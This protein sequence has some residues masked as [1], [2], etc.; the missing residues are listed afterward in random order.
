MIIDKNLF[1]KFLR[2]ISLDG[3]INDILLTFDDQGM[4]AKVKNASSSIVLAGILKK[5]A[6][7]NYQPLN[8]KIGLKS[9]E[10]LL[11]VLKKYDHELIILIDEEK[12]N[13]TFHD[14]KKRINYQLL[15]PD[16]VDSHI[17]ALPKIE[18]NTEILIP[19]DILRSVKDVCN[20]YDS[21]IEIK[22]KN[23]QA[24]FTTKIG[25][26]ENFT[27]K[28]ELDYKDMR[29]LFGYPLFQ[30]IPIL[31]D[32]VLVSM[33]DNRPMRITEE[34]EYYKIKYIIAQREE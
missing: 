24:Y 27:E 15:H 33:D 10:K 8:I 12:S 2:K 25:T 7:K 16:Y 6:F 32:E 21:L 3:D 19:T 18:F 31:N 20:M 14:K 13:I 30:V 29:V 17:K 1:T 11:T 5:E 9:I 26:E 23:K 4:K 34:D 28:I 22:V